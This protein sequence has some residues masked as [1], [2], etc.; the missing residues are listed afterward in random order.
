MSNRPSRIKEL[1]EIE[2]GLIEGGVNTDPAVLAKR[3][4]RVIEII[5]QDWQEK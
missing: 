4:A 2:R 3:L 5:V 1:K